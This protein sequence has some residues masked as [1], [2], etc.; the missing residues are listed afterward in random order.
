MLWTA[1]REPPCLGRSSC[2]LPA[3]SGAEAGFP[4][5]TQLKNQTAIINLMLALGASA[6]CQGHLRLC[7]QA[8]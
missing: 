8:V 4:V 3:W 5:A 7:H 6:S 2:L 1:S